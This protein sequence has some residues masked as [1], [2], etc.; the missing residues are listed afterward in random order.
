[1]IRIVKLTQINPD[2]IIRKASQLCWRSGTEWGRWD[3]E[4]EKGIAYS[5]WDLE[6][7]KYATDTSMI[8]LST[9]LTPSP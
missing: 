8:I 5:F 4:M 1:M 7:G 3:P 2:D 9:Y 6:D